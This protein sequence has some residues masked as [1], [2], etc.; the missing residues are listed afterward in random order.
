MRI[1]LV[2][3]DIPPGL[4]IVLECAPPLGLMYIASYL[5]KARP[6]DEVRIVDCVLEELD[7]AKVSQTVESFRPRLV[8]IS[9]MSIHAP[10]LH[11]IATQI[12]EKLP[13]TVIVVGGPHAAAAQDRILSDPDVDVVIPGEGEATF[14]E[15][16][17]A[18][19]NNRQLNKVPGMVIRDGDDGATVIST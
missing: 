10:V 6:A 3:P 13:E 11:Q 17:D 1:L 15:L 9:A 7:P 19:D 2:R 8:G 12:K 16:V 14:L 4:N 18:L 5:L